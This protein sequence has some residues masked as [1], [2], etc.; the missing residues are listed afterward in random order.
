MKDELPQENPWR[1]RVSRIAF[2]LSL[3]SM[4]MVLYISYQIYVPVRILEMKVTPIPLTK[5][6]VM[7]GESIGLIANYCK[8]K[9]IPSLVTVT[10]LNHHLAPSLTTVRNF[11]TGCHVGKEALIMDINIPENLRPNTYKMLIFIDYS[12][13]NLRKEHYQFESEEFQVIESEVK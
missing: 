11:P 3:W 2:H 5:T 8:Y 6:T 12:V 7:Q 10:F 1:R 13:S 4:I 9:N